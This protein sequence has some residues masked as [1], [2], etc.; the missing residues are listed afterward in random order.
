MEL[1]VLGPG[2]DFRGSCQYLGVDGCGILLDAGIDLSREGEAG[3]PDLSAIG[4]WPLDWILLSHAHLD[5]CGSLPIVLQ[6]WPRAR[7]LCTPAT[8]ELTRLQLTRRAVLMNRAFHEGRSPDFPLYTVADLELL[9]ESV[10]RIRHGE[11]RQLE[12]SWNPAGVRVSAHDAGHILGSIGFRLE[13][14]EAIL[15]STGDT[16]LRPQS[17]IQ[18]ASL[19]ASAD[20]VLTKTTMAWSDFHQDNTRRDEIQRLESAI[21]DVERMGGSI[22]MPVFNLGR[23]Q[24]LLFILHSL[25][26][27]G[28]IPP[29]PIH[30]G[31]DAWHVADVYDAYAEGDRRLLPDFAFRDTLV[32]IYSPDMVDRVHEGGSEIYLVSS[33]MLSPDSLSWDLARRLLPHAVHG[34]F[35]SGHCAGG[36]IGKAVLKAG[37][38]ESVPFGDGDIERHCR[39]ESFHFSAHSSRRELVE[40]LERIEPRKVLLLEGRK[41]SR[42]RLRE[43]L[44]GRLDAEVLD[45]EIGRVTALLDE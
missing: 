35:F 22:L 2:E 23:A 7:I 41:D 13:G 1:I 40:M 30:V 16:C 14:E 18:G 33:G 36:T 15:F 29:L 4:N 17:V 31:E 12:G 9:E 6:R 44:A 45:L 21:R 10:V 27:K 38:G 43:A 5:H 19:P 32:D 37:P 26:K 11:S 8:W 28:R 3:L 20:M 39:V 25:K 24:E 42:A 34:I